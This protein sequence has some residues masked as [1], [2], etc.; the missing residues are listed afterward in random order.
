MAPPPPPLLHARFRLTAGGSW[1]TLYIYM[2]TY[3][4]GGRGL[5]TLPTPT[6]PLPPSGYPRSL[7][8]EGGW[9]GRS[10]EGG[11]T[12]GVEAGSSQLSKPEAFASGF[13]D[14][15]P[16]PPRPFLRHPAPEF[17]R[18]PCQRTP[19]NLVIALGGD[20]G[21]SWVFHPPLRCAREKLFRRKRSGVANPRPKMGA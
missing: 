16:H 21:S 7:G 9:S 17:P 6:L 8:W 10:L 15:P 19:G 11:G 20:L 12:S 4:C 2:A 18:H 14:T 5:G 1:Q 3:F 13:A